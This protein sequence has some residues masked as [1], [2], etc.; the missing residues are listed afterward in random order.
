MRPFGSKRQADNLFPLKSFSQNDVNYDRCP[1]DR[2][3]GI[4]RYHPVLARQIAHQ[5]TDQGDHG[6][7]EN[8]GRQQRTV[9][10]G[11]EQQS[12]D[13]RHGQSDKGHRSAEGGSDGGQDARHD[14]QPVA[15]AHNVDAQ[16]LGILVAQHQGVQRFDEQQCAYQSGD[17]HG[18]KHGHRLH[19]HA[20]KRSHAPY[21]IRFHALV[22]GEEVQQRDG[23]V[24]D[25]AYH[26]ADDEQHHVVAHDVREEEDERHH[27]HG[28]DKS[29]REDGHEAR[30]AHRARRDA[31][32]QEQ[33]HQGHAQSGTAV[34]T[35]DARSC[36]G[37]AEGRLQ[38]QSAHGERPTAE[39]GGDRLWQSRFQYD[40]PPR[41]LRRLVAR[42]YADHIPHR[43]PH[44]SHHQVHRKQHHHQPY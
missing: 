30:E 34:D 7:A 37:V 42:Q 43:N 6:A 15:G 10:V 18:G 44:R 21:H 33:H 17:G 29:R 24:R 35:E 13:V 16:V 3:D 11:A 41:R 31:T 8:S 36:Q 26:D 9:V 22:G 32:P 20:A 4:Q 39:H 12:G 5:V 14:Q 38:H 1:H 23:R 19:R 27:R 28:A 2:C 25:I 40:K